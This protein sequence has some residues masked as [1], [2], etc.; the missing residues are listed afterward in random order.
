M[1]SHPRRDFYN[2]LDVLEKDD[3][4][5]DDDDMD[6][7]EESTLVAILRDECVLPLL[8]MLPFIYASGSRCIP[9]IQ[10]DGTSPI[11][12]MLMD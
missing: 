1:P 3:G 11:W 10:R 6:W 5:Y 8:N 7:D 9:Y 12:R 2:D 4:S